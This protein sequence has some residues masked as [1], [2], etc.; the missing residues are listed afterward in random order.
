MGEATGGSGNWWEWQLRLYKS[1]KTA[2]E[3]QK[4]KRQYKARE[5][6]T[7]EETAIAEEG[8]AYGSGEF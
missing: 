3:V 5:K 7:A 1:H 4:K 6:V 2:N 8:P